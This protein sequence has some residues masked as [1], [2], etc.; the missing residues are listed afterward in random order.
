M[1]K[2]RKSLAQLVR[3]FILRRTKDKVLKELPPRTEITLHAE[4]SKA[5]RSRYED[6]EVGGR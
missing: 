2:K 1:T 3:P 4:L 5:E 6:A